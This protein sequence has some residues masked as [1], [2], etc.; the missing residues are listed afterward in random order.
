M[1]LI[2]ILNYY[3]RNFYLVCLVSDL[4]FKLDILKY[5]KE[6]DECQQVSHNFNGKNALFTNSIY[7]QEHSWKYLLTVFLFTSFNVKIVTAIS[8]YVL[9]AL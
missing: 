7:Y 6:R 2:G 4:T 1:K 8:L 3:I 5:K 9:L